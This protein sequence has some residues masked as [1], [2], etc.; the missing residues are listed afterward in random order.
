MSRTIPVR[1]SFEDS[2]LARID[3]QRPKPNT[4]RKG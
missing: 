2:V 4:N 1:R 3:R